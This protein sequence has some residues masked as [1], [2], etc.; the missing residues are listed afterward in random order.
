M[1]QPVPLPRKSPMNTATRRLASLLA[2]LALAYKL[3]PSLTLTLLALLLVVTIHEAGHYLAARCLNLHTPEFA[4]GL[5][6][7]V[8]QRHSSAR[9]MDWSLR[10]IPV[11]GFV[12]IAGMDETDAGQDAALPNGKRTWGDL[13]RGQRVVLAAAGPFAN[14]VLAIVLVMIVLVGVG[15]PQLTN[16]RISPVDKSPAQQAGLKEGDV[17]VAVDSLPIQSFSQLRDVIAALPIDKPVGL[18][19]MRDEKFMHFTVTTKE[20][21]SH[22]ILGV[23]AAPTYKAIT[24]A[25][26]LSRTT[27]VSW[28]L[29]SHTA[30]GLAQ[31]LN[32]ITSIPANFIN[33]EN[34]DAP[35][36]LSPVGAA[37]VAE[38]A[39]RSDG[40][41]APLLL[42][43]NASMFIGAFNLLPVP[44]LDGGHIAIA[45]YETVMTRVRRRQVRV[46]RQALLPVTRIVVTFIL[47]LSVSS[48]VLDVF[49]PIVAP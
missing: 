18:D 29:V 46:S 22:A 17:V 14:V 41:Y 48:L 43:A 47:L 7:V 32:A 2:V 19:V 9:E 26:L 36:L 45:T 21:D 5:G 49:R 44:P 27:S 11:G 28:K 10:A 3:H 35:R 31:A 38:S 40:W 25:E 12:K 15:T 33:G 13:N 8:L 4:V 1:T 24:P 37:K 23:S 16:A 6:P 39:S 20:S 34:S 30:S 42:L